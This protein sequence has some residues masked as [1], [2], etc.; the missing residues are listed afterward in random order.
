MAW[1]WIGFGI[2]VLGG[3]IL[4]GLIRFFMFVDDENDD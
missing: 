4:S 3:L 2:I 1:S